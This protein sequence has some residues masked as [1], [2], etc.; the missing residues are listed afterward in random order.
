MKVQKGLEWA[1]QSCFKECMKTGWYNIQI[2][3]YT[4]FSLGLLFLRSQQFPYLLIETLIDSANACI[5][6]L[7]LMI[8]FEVLQFL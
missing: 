1:C 2:T 4:H 5:I 6:I 8:R 7:I 3:L